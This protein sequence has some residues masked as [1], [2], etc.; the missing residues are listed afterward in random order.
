MVALYSQHQSAIIEGGWKM[1]KNV[2]TWVWSFL[3]LIFYFVCFID[4]FHADNPFYLYSEAKHF[5]L[6]P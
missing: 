2:R 5:I 4:I 1:I 6:S 3:F